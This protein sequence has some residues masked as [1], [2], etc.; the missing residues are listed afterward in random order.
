MQDESLNLIIIGAGPLLEDCF[1]LCQA[2]NLNFQF[3]NLNKNKKNNN[4]N[5]VFTG[6]LENPFSVIRNCG[7]FV[8]P[9]FYEGLSNQLLEAI[10]TGIPIIASDCPGNKFVYNEIY[11]DDCKYINS[12]YFQLLPAI[13]SKAGKLKWLKHLISHTK[14]FKIGKYK[15]GKKIIFKFSL[16]NNF[17]KWN[18]LISDIYKE[19]LYE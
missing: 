12:N 17:P 18:K 9:S 4:N 15:N 5:I 13:N 8:M 16:E 11:K 2:L 6:H 7:L 10:Y 1:K 14:N 19:R 3:N